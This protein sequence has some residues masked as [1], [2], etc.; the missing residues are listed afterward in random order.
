LMV[1]EH[2]QRHDDHDR[3]R[4]GVQDVRLRH[5]GAHGTGP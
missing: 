4:E 1:Q 5:L 2:D 3:D